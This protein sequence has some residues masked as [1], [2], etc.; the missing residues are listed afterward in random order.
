MEN[1]DNIFYQRPADNWGI[2]IKYLD[3]DDVGVF[4]IYVKLRES[5]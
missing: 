4:D 2:Q 5:L 3:L 1:V